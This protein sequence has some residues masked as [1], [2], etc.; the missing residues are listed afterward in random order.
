VQR[1]R[2]VD[3]NEKSKKK[4]ELSKQSAKENIEEDLKAEYLQKIQ[5]VQSQ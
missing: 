1:L 4:F 3:Q 2:R 5:K